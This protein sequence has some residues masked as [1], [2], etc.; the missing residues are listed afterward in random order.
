MH[1]CRSCRCLR[2]PT[3]VNTP[4]G[5]RECCVVLSL[6]WQA[7]PL[8]PDSEAPA[9]AAEAGQVHRC[10]PEK[11]SQGG[12]CRPWQG[13]PPR[14]S[15]ACGCCC[16]L[17]PY[18]VLVVLGNCRAG[19]R[20]RKGWGWRGGGAGEGGLLVGGSRGVGPA[21]MV[22]VA[23][24]GPQPAVPAAGLLGGGRPGDKVGV[25][26]AD[27]TVQ[28]AGEHHVLCTRVLHQPR[29]L[30]RLAVHAEPLVCRAACRAPY[31]HICDPATLPP[32]R[33]CVRARRRCRSRTS[34]R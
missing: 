7:R 34:T 27:T 19:C 25:A 5:A 17:P 10:P 4:G 15:T 18:C 14:P 26:A 9:R 31:M 1:G 23:E 11:L 21:V 8:P 29:L 13:L 2:D 16:L 30:S 28:A 6:W 24:G 22:G 33:S 20:G 32:V 12:D 3:V